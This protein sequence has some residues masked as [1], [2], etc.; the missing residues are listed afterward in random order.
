MGRPDY[1]RSP[2]TRIPRSATLSRW[3]LAAL[4]IWTP[5]RV[6]AR[7]NPYDAFAKIIRPFVRLLAV[8][9]SG[10]D[11]AV[12]LVGK[13]DDVTGF[14]P[15]LKGVSL[16]LSLEYPDK[17]LIVAPLM[18]EVVTICR[19]GTTIWIYP[20]SKLKE[21]LAQPEIVEKLPE[22]NRKFKLAPLGLPLPEKELAFLPALFEVT[23]GG[24]GNLE[25]VICQ[26][27]DVKLMPALRKSLKAEEWSAR[28]WI[29]PDGQLVKLILQRGKSAAA[30]NFS[31]IQFERHMPPATWVPGKDQEGDVFLVP[32]AR[33]DQLIRAIFG[34][35]K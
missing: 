35:R 2:E 1:R 17:M 28:L 13:V 16:D 31:L 9:V 5:L 6:T 25:G 14:T 12:H 27:L 15:D 34:E 10:E 20:G 33:Y 32:P 21:L 24:D 4:L 8:R 23:D 18:G 11:R 22:P 29:N 19:Q 26:V 3:L 7:D 30:I